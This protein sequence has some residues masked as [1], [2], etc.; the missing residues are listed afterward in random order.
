MRTFEE[1]DGDSGV[2][3]FLDGF[4]NTCAANLEGPGGPAVRNGGAFLASESYHLRRQ[5]TCFGGLSVRSRHDAKVG[6]KLQRCG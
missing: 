1:N 4:L 5:L 2:S 6:T 3:H